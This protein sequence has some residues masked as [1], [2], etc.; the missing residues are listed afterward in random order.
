M[1]AE[2]IQ[3]EHDV[4]VEHDNR[5]AEFNDK[6]VESIEKVLNYLELNN[7]FISGELVNNPDIF[8]NDWRNSSAIAPNASRILSS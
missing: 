8:S 3:F 4:A 7:A 1:A 6:L 5:L 2:T